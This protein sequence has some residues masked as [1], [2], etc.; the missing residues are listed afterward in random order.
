MN[1]GF[2][3]P[4]VGLSTLASATLGSAELTA[5]NQAA[6][7]GERKTRVARSGGEGGRREKERREGRGT[8]EKHEQKRLRKNKNILVLKKVT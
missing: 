2:A 4:S 8:R 7:S 6:G 5:E 3:E 1:A